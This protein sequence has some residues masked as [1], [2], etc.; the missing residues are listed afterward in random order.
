MVQA[1]PNSECFDYANVGGIEVGGFGGGGC[2]IARTDG[3]N[4]VDVDGVVLHV[5]GTDEIVSSNP[6]RLR[7]C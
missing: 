4:G 7:R 3:V 6:P 1:Q 5:G 2:I